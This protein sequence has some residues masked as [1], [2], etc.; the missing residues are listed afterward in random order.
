MLVLIVA[1]KRSDP[2]FDSRMQKF[3]GKSLGSWAIVGATEEWGAGRMEGTI[4]SQRRSRAEDCGRSA[5]ETESEAW[6][7][8]TYLSFLATCT[9]YQRKVERSGR[10]K[11]EIGGS[12][13]GRGREREE[14]GWRRAGQVK[15]DNR[16]SQWQAGVWIA[17]RAGGRARAGDRARGRGGALP[18]VL[19]CCLASRGWGAGPGGAWSKQASKQ[20]ST[21][22]ERAAERDQ[23][24]REEG[25]RWSQERGLCA[26]SP[27]AVRTS[28]V[29][30]QTRPDQPQ[31][32]LSHVHAYAHAYS[33]AHAAADFPSRP[34]GR[35]AKSC[36]L[37]HARPERAP[38]AKRAPVVELVELA[39]EKRGARAGERRGEHEHEHE[40]QDTPAPAPAWTGQRRP[41]QASSSFPFRVC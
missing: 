14:V 37:L 21:Q 36:S 40:Q 17:G 32:Q 35:R 25:L 31:Q 8:S 29:L 1:S 10:E 22:R 27:S 3:R 7:A 15:M 18:P 16:G 4:N 26:H 11:R 2:C 30:Y 19:G 13:D 33:H 39:R 9:S 20:A 23:G 24:T 34:T 41:A 38:C 12:G 5:R 6:A 28:T